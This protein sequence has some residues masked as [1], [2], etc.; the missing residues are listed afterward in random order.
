VR[1]LISTSTPAG[2]RSRPTLAIAFACL[3]LAAALFASPV[4]AKEQPPARWYDWPGLEKCRGTFTHTYVYK[5][6]VD[7]VSCRFG[8]RLVRKF[9]SG[10]GVSGGE[11]S[12]HVAGFEGWTCG[13]G[14]G[15]GSC[16]KRSKTVGWQ[17][18]VK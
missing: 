14:S 3:V 2:T 6:Y 9:V 18:R 15:G 8:T 1:Q 10:R 11:D 4:G 16:T 13:E 5:V 7:K 17:N 12:W